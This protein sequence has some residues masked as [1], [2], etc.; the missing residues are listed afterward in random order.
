MR[1][2]CLSTKYL[3][4]ALTG[5]THGK[6]C[7]ISSKEDEV[8]DARSEGGWSGFERCPYLRED[9]RHCP[10]HDPLPSALPLLPSR[11]CPWQHP[12]GSSGGRPSMAYAL[13]YPLPEVTVWKKQ[14]AG[15]EVTEMDLGCGWAWERG[16]G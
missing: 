9:K 14:L 7:S 13:P 8:A 1:P 6:A 3:S 12:N 16:Q 5:T 10:V 2:L 11:A 4:L 15:F